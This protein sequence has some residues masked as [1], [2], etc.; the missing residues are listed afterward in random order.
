M[1]T[2]QFSIGK[3]QFAEDR[4]VVIAEAGVNHLGDIAKARELISAAARAGADIIKFQTYKASKLTTSY[5]ERFWSWEG[6]VDPEGTQLD[7]YSKLDSFGPEEYKILKDICE[8]Y[9]IEFMSTPFDEDA[10]AMLV[11]VGVKG[12][13]IA[14]CDIT[15][16]PLLKKIGDTRLPVLLSTGGSTIA[17]IHA[18]LN[19]LELSGSG[20][21]L[22]MQCTLTYPT[23][24][25]D[26]NLSA[27][28]HLREEFPNNLIGLS[29]HS[30][31]IE[32]PAASVLMGARA[33]EKHFT[34][35]KT[36]PLSADHWLSVDEAELT[37]LVLNAKMFAKA[38]G[39]GGKRVLDSELLARTNA[40]RSIVAARQLSVGE[41]L[42][43]NDV[44]FKRP[45]TGI[46]PGEIDQLIGREITVPFLPDEQ[47]TREKLG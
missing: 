22:I 21:V 35:D 8:E 15:N 6:E 31:G 47:L 30:L 32:I 17:E 28:L 11:D 1:E 20:P 46:P 10:V 16:L 23:P 33:I 42:G 3:V 25:E 19:T 14:S 43:R 24:A 18:A 26:A 44:E 39:Q 36:L 40:R 41:V 5:A 12:F 37:Q 34:Y 38:I 2:K 13:K 27:I 45:G 29:D 4:V 7:S 9:G